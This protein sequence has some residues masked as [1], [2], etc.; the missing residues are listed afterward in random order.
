MHF[1]EVDY[2]RVKEIQKMSF[3][4]RELNFSLPNNKEHKFIEGK[5]TKFKINLSS[6]K[7]K[8]LNLDKIVVDSVYSKNKLITAVYKKD[9]NKDNFGP[10]IIPKNK[11][12]VIGDNR[13]NSEDSRFIGLIDKKDV[14]GIKI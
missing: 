13:D 9:W 8:E 11:Y 6:S 7:A 2:K 10:I 3:Y 12:F 1:Y 5:T 4:K 14:I